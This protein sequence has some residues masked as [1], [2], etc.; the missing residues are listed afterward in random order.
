MAVDGRFTAWCCAHS[1]GRRAGQG[2]SVG[3][4][5]TANQGHVALP[6]LHMA[7]FCLHLI[8]WNRVTW[9]LHCDHVP[10]EGAWGGN[11]FIWA[12]C[13]PIQNHRPVSE[14]KKTMGDGQILMGL[15]QMCYLLPE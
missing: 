7:L 10:F 9:P 11:Y 14:E 12:H 6:E 4:A 3:L 2:P 13:H 1:P 15:C 5:P 8:D